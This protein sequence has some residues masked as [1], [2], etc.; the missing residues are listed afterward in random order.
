MTKDD[1]KEYTS[2]KREL[3][4]IQFKLKEL[5]E[6]KTSI[7]SQIIS[8]MPRGGGDGKELLDILIGIED[9][10]KKLN[11]KITKLIK[12]ISEIEDTIENLD[13]IER[14]LIRYKYIENLKMFQIAEK[15][16]YSER[17]LNR[18]HSDVLKRIA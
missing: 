16:N 9:I 15:M 11:K 8:D 4:Q 2:I 14:L 6:R 13:T 7:K 17:H 10:I 5:E 12:K 18:V 3:K 1:L